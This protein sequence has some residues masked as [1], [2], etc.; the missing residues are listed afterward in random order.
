M[1]VRQN[2]SFRSRKALPVI[3]TLMINQSASRSDLKKA[4]ENRDPCAIL[5]Q[6]LIKNGC[7]E[8]MMLEIEKK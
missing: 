1:K 7:D 2:S 8:K 3:L 5:R 6:Y 4:M